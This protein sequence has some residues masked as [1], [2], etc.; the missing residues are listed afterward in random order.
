MAKQIIIEVSDQFAADLQE[1]AAATG[2]LLGD[3]VGKVLRKVINQ[4]KM[5]QQYQL[6]QRAREAE[7]VE[8]RIADAPGR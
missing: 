8:V 4:H 2:T 1:A 6:Q 7:R 5:N 3:T